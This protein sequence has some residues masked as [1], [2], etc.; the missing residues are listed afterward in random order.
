M[1]VEYDI[2]T[3]VVFRHNYFSG[4]KL[5]CIS[6]HPGQDTALQMLNIGLLFKSYKDGFALIYEKSR[7]GQERGKKELLDG[8]VKLRF[9]IMLT[10]SNFFNYTEGGMDS[11]AD[12]VYYF[13]NAN[14]GSEK[15]MKLHKDE[16]VSQADIYPSENLNGKIHS[17]PFAFVEL[18]LDEN[19]ANEYTITFREKQTYWRYLLLS[20][21]LKSL[22][23]PA[24]LGEQVV[25]SGPE[26]L[27]L[28][29]QKEALC[30][31]STAPISLSQVPAKHFM[32]VENY[33]NQTSAY[34][35]VM[36]L[37]P[38]PNINNISSAKKNEKNMYSEIFIY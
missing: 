2:L 4:L 9:N 21:H 37:L 32:L 34:R 30:F 24:I 16:F 1:E 3:H 35:V 20:E 27:L 22:Q 13:H 10:D 18:R 15:T 38:S 14:A 33:E 25:F 23:N 6:V 8:S 17:K 5:E 12:S 28:P 29:D 26:K 11:L 36:R 19:L 31:E 7:D